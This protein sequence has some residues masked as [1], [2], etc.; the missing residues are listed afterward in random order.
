MAAGCLALALAFGC[1]SAP[2]GGAAPVASSA[3]GPG[4]TQAASSS[5][6]G[7]AEP[8]LVAS[9]VAE[10]EAGEAPALLHLVN[11]SDALYV[12]FQIGR[13]N[14]N[15]IPPGQTAAPQLSFSADVRADLKLG[16]HDPSLGG[17]GCIFFKPKLMN[18]PNA[19]V[20]G[21]RYQVE[22]TGTEPSDVVLDI[23]EHEG[24]PFMGVRAWNKAAVPGTTAVWLEVA[25][26]S[27]PL[28]L[29]TVIPEVPS[30]YV[31]LAE[32]SEPAVE[33]TRVRFAMNGQDLAADLTVELTGA[34][35]FT[36][37]IDSKAV[38]GAMTSAAL[39]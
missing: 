37:V 31:L 38:D 34:A 14:F 19:W 18:G 36:A 5:S 10:T 23:T 32:G 28:E 27:P 16:Y 29:V 39:E 21:R 8:S 15:A 4:T 25:G 6:T 13:A 22:A 20:P 12:T 30:S 9:F 33:V 26:G 17:G 24:A 35:G 3:S 11:A 1:S 7:T 2:G